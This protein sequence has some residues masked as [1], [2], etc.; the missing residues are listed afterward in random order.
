MYNIYILTFKILGSEYCGQ[1]L[2]NFDQL[3]PI[4]ANL[5]SKL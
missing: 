5:I 2:L 1:F 4:L 3:V